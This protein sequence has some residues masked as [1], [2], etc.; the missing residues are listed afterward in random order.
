MLIPPLGE[1][2][3][4]RLGGTSTDQGAMGVGTVVVLIKNK[5]LPPVLSMQAEHNHAFPENV[6]LTEKRKDLLV[7]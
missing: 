1:D 2:T 5:G 6:R 3:L 7:T 4:S